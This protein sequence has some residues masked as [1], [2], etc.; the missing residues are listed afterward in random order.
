[1]KFHKEEV[2]ESKSFF[3]CQHNPGCSQIAIATTIEIPAEWDCFLA[4]QELPYPRSP[5]SFRTPKCST[6][7]RLLLFKR[8]NTLNLTER[9][10]ID[11]YLDQNGNIVFTERFLIERKVCC[12]LGC[13]HCP[14]FPKHKVGN[15]ELAVNL[16][17]LRFKRNMQK[18]D[19]TCGLSTK[20]I[21]IIKYN[22]TNSISRSYLCCRIQLKRDFSWKEEMPG[23]SDGIC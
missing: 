7:A 17:P 18:F 2:H 3:I 6:L 15:K 1:M 10:K 13:K 20:K 12:G 21:K 11:R 16:K 9:L 19:Q 5:N 14:Y 23:C 4:M 22:V 8:V